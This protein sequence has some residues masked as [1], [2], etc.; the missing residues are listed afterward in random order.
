MY[1]Y[2]SDTKNIYIGKLIRMKVDER[3]ISYAEFAR[4]I[5]RSRTSLYHIFESKTID[6]DLLITIS[7][8]LDYDFIRNI[9]MRNLPCV[10]PAERAGK[11][12]VCTSD[13]PVTAPACLLLPIERDG[14]QLSGLPAT[15]VDML[16]E[17]LS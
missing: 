14:I 17:A 15:L 5:N 9:Y 11:G 10:V 16:R 3:H 7:K 12:G 13:M 4:M 8:V 1:D 2:Y 6:I